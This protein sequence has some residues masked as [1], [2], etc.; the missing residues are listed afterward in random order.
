[1]SNGVSYVPATSQDLRRH[2]GVETS[3]REMQLAIVGV[4]FTPVGTNTCADG[5]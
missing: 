1:M 2:K 3:G 4:G 5:W